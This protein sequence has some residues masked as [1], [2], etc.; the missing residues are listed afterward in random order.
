M[1]TWPA[2]GRRGPSK[3]RGHHQRRLRALLCWHF[4]LWPVLAFPVPKWSWLSGFYGCQGSAIFFGKIEV[5][6]LCFGSSIDPS[7]PHPAER[8]LKR[9]LSATGNRNAAMHKPLEC[10]DAFPLHNQITNIYFF[11]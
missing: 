6:C 11:I 9:H 2:P 8:P 5:V 1:D 10:I 3:G 7:R 4:R